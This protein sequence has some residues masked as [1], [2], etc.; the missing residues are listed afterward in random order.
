MNELYKIFGIKWKRPLK[1]YE[2]LLFLWANL[3]VCGLAVDMDATPY[4]V[5]LLIV[6]NFCASI[7]ACANVLP[8][9]M[10]IEE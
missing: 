9:L 6:I 7:W 10:D 4:W 5:I 1:W 8:D 2:K 3:A